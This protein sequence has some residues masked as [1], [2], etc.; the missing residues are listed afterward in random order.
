M[1][2]LCFDTSGEKGCVAVIK[3]G[4]IAGSIVLSKIYGHN[5]TLLPSAKI[6]VD[7]LNIKP[8]EINIV[9]FVR[10]PGS[11]TGLRIGIA[12]AYGIN[13]ANP[14]IEL[15]GYTSLFLHARQ[16]LKQG[17][18]TLV[19]L[20]ARKKQVYAALFKSNGE[21]FGYKNIYPNE[22]ERLVLEA[23]VEDI[24]ITGNGYLKYKEVIDESLKIQFSYEQSQECL[25][26]PLAEEILNPLNF[27]KPSIEP[28][29]IRK[30]DAEVNRDKKRK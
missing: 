12:T 19:L 13:A 10:G 9:G 16:F 6:L 26:I 15:K 20:D 2:C 18:D 3:D 17:K 8:E 11:F 5:E 22:I 30:S 23:G 28:L 21:K 25:A 4:K 7:K 1:N 14:N 24:V 27:E 29:Y